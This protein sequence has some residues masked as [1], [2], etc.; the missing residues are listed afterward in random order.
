MFTGVVILILVCILAAAAFISRRRFG[1]LALAMA[2]GYIISVYQAG[3]V[4][5]MLRGYNLS[6]GAM[7]LDTAV[8]MAMIIVPSIVLFFGGPTYVNKRNRILG[9]IAYGLTALF[10]CLGSL[11]HSLVLIGQEKLVYSFILDYREQAI[12]LLL[13]I[14]MIDSFFIHTIRRNKRSD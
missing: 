1:I 10:F 8:T 6:L 3:Y 5:D 12:V 14:A 13:V 2:A 4:A 7:S 11:E 9:S